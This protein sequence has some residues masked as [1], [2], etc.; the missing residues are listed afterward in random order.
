MTK[1]PEGVVGGTLPNIPV[2]D[3]IP[4]KW[5]DSTTTACGQSPQRIHCRR[6]NCRSLPTPSSFLSLTYFPC[7]P[8]SSSPPGSSGI[9]TTS[10]LTDLK[11]KDPGRDPSPGP[12]LAGTNNTDSFYDHTSGRFCCRW[13]WCRWCCGV[14]TSSSRRSTRR[15]TSA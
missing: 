5:P 13:C 1:R 10:I 3:A 7:L 2:D 9:L 12:S 4:L 8:C 11:D 6:R 15:R 14:C